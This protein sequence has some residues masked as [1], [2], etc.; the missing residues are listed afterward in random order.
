MTIQSVV[1]SSGN[2]AV[3]SALIQANLLSRHRLT[4]RLSSG[5]KRRGGSCVAKYLAA[6]SQA[7]AVRPSSFHEVR[8]RRR[9]RWNRYLASQLESKLE[10]CMKSKLLH[11]ENGLKTFA[12]VFDKEEEV[13]EK[14]LAFANTNRF[15]MHA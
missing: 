5:R 2:L 9:Y 4:A 3:I 11:D 8:G 15:Q 1:F 10:V 6:G 7:A 14:L 13:R 12:I